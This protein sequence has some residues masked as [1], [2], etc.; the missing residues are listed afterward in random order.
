L[1]TLKLLALSERLALRF[2]LVLVSAGTGGR[3]N[4]VYFADRCTGANRSKL[5]CGATR[6][7]GYRFG[8]GG[9][10]PST[11]SGRCLGRSPVQARRAGGTQ[12][13]V[14]FRGRHRDHRVALVGMGKSPAYAQG[15]RADR[16]IGSGT[17]GNDSDR[18]RRRTGFD[19]VRT[20][21]LPQGGPV[22]GGSRSCSHSPYHLYHHALGGRRPA[23]GP[24]RA[25][26]T[27]LAGGRQGIGGLGLD[28]PHGRQRERRCRC[29]SVDAG[30]GIRPNG[31]WRTVVLLLDDGASALAWDGA[32][33]D[34]GLRGGS[35]SF[36]DLLIT[37]WPTFGDCRP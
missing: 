16:P 17:A 2:N 23:V 22:R 37:G 19:A 31:V 27:P 6:F 29:A 30:M 26:R 25:G 12:L 5:R 8:A 11:C 13:P 34:W 32:V 24:S 7:G 20:L 10:Q 15:R 1:L 35:F 21:S 4:W 18:T 36:P 33:R 3:R 9:A 14:Q 28:C